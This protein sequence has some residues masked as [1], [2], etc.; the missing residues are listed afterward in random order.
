[1]GRVPRPLKIKRRMTCNYISACCYLQFF[2]TAYHIHLVNLPST[3]RGY[4]QNSRRLGPVLNNCAGSLARLPLTRI[5]EKTLSAT[6][7]KKTRSSKNPA[8]LCEDQNQ[9]FPPWLCQ[10]GKNPTTTLRLGAS[11]RLRFAYEGS[12]LNFW[13]ILVMESGRC[14]AAR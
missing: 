8:Q 10:W 3:T 4:L 7:K 1:M 6:T 12:L 2:R 5:Q 13:W 9:G 14:V 11:F